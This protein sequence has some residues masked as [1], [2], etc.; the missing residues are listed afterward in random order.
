MDFEFDTNLNG[1]IISPS[2]VIGAGSAVNRMISEG[3]KV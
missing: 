3:Y 1:A 2:D